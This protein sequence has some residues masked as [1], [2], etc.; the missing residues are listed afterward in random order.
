M[1]PVNASPYRSILS[2]AAE[3]TAAPALQVALI[4]GGPYAGDP[5][6]VIEAGTQTITI[7][8]ASQPRF[9]RLRWCNPARISSIAIA[10]TTLVLK[11][12]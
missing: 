3:P 11:Y 7:P 9:Y 4:P 6:G 10:G 1:I 2:T 8:L 5:T 12:Q